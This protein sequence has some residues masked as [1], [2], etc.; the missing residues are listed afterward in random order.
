MRITLLSCLLLLGVG[1]AQAEKPKPLKALL[2]TGGCC[3][4]YTKQKVILSEGISQRANV[5]WTIIQEGGGGTAHNVSIH[6][7][8]DWAKAYDIVVHNEC[9][10]GTTDLDW[11]H[12]ITDAHKAGVPGLVIHCAMHCY[13]GKTD[14]WFKFCGVRSHG[15]GAQLPI[16][17]DLAKPEHPIVKGLPA[18]WTTVPTE[19]YAISE[20]YDSTTSLADGI[21]VDPKTQDAS[22]QKHSCIWVGQFGKGKV[23]GT[24]LG[25]HNKEF[26]DPMYLDFVSRG[27]LWACG[28]LGD[29]G[30]PLPGYEGTGVKAAPKPSEPQPTPAPPRS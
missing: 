18:H 25:H 29:D 13:R 17:I 5:E 21:Q 14:Q 2:I 28:K 30:K 9:F 24:T 7:K 1:V 27:L 23:F 22:P 20:V 6:E 16:E 3:H 10:A 4:D 12:N 15:H 8:K 19:M 26:E 11:I